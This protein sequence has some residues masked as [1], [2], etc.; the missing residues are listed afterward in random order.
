VETILDNKQ[1]PS[2]GSFR[3]GLQITEA[4]LAGQGDNLSLAYFNTDGSNALSVAYT[5]PINARDGTLTL[6]YRPQWT[7]ITEEP[8]NVLDIQGRSQDISLSFRQPI[9]QTPSRELALGLQLTHRES[10]TTLSGVQFPLSAGADVDGK[11]Q[12][13]VLRFSQEYLQRGQRQVIAARSQL[14]LGMDILNA[15]TNPQPPDGRFISWLGQAQWVRQ[16]APDTLFIARTDIQLSDRSLVPLEQISIGGPDTVR[17]YRQNLLLANSG[18]VFTAE[19]RVP[20]LRVPKVKGLLQIAPFIDVGTA[21]GRSDASS[22]LPSTIA[23]IG[24]GLQWQ[25]GRRFFVRLDYG[26]P[27]ISVGSRRRSLQEQ[28][29]SFSVIFRP[30]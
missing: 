13:T 27:L 24:L 25:M 9:I 14:S 16:L 19:A 21:F 20:I 18:A 30:Y 17:G 22:G 4:N 11:T 12:L 6:S 28:G 23:S 10:Q 7:R 1:T 3:R 15:T 5:Y 2:V 8:F 29:F 26:V